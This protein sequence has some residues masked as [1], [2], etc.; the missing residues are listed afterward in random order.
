MMM[1]SEQGSVP[2]TTLAGSQPILTVRDMRKSFLVGRD[3]L[4]RHKLLLHA[5]RG[6]SFS[7]ERGETLGLVGESGCGKT[8]LARLILQLIR[9]DSGSVYLDGSPDLCTLS[10]AALRPYRRRLQIIFQDPYGS[11]NPRMTVG[12]IVGEPLIIHR[13]CSK[14]ERQE[15]VK[16]LLHEVGLSPRAMNRFP[17]EFSGGQ[18]QRIGIARALAVGPDVIVADEPV[19]ALDVS[20]RSQIIN[21]LERLQEQFQIAYLFVSHDLSVVAHLSHR[22]AVMYLGELV[23]IAP[24]RALFGEPLHPYTQALL[25]AVPQPDP[26]RKAPRILLRGEVPSPVAPP[27]GCSFHPRCPLVF[28]PCST[29]KPTLCE[30]RPNHFVACHLYDPE[31]VRTPVS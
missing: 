13:L 28:Q 16:A 7:L 14:K 29:A 26:K 3:A 8:T 22:V 11:L 19:S 24:K 25:A 1:S 6:V 12:S 31:Y 18:R 20:I 17:H 9:P 5:V 2:N 23:E 15:R 27:S 4:W 21:L 10:Q 30:V